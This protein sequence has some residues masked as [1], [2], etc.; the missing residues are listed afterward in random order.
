[1]QGVAGG[2]S[3]NEELLEMVTAQNERIKKLT[4]TV[5]MLTETLLKGAQPSGLAGDIRAD[6]Q[7]EWEVDRDI[8]EE[9]NRLK[10]LDG[11]WDVD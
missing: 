10:R 3:D 9:V 1:M 5:G 7:V 2:P 6:W 8:E 4:E 11:R